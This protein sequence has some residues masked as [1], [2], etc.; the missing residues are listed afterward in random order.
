M[1]YAYIDL[2][3]SDLKRAVPI[4]RQTL[5][6]RHA[7]VRSWLLF[8]DDELAAEWIGIHPQTPPP[9]SAIEDEGE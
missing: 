9:P 4:I 6:E 8:H 7:P 2:A 3:L 1:R 5:A